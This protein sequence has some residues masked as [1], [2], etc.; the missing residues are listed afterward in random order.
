MDLLFTSSGIKRYYSNALKLIQCHLSCFIIKN[1]S[2]KK[3]NSVN[4][5]YSPV[6]VTSLYYSVVELKSLKPLR[7]KFK[8][9]AT[10]ILWPCN[11]DVLILSK[12]LISFPICPCWRLFIPSMRQ[13]PFRMQ[14]NAI[15]QF[16]FLLKYKTLY[17]IKWNQY[18]VFNKLSTEIISHSWDSN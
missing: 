18:I 13:I 15:H 8:R 11:F 6:V 3:T 7:K 10:T 17:L 2:S 5:L 1:W 16:C 12:K 14:E 4:I 9:Y